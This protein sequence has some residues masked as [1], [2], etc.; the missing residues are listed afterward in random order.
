M[1]AARRSRHQ[2]SRAAAANTHGLDAKTE[3]NNHFCCPRRAECRRASARRARS[4][5]SRGKSGAV[6][7]GF[8]KSLILFNF[9]GRVYRGGGECGGAIAL[10]ALAFH[11]S[12]QSAGRARLPAH[13]HAGRQVGGRPQPGGVPSVS[14]P[15]EG[16]AP[17]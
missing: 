5:E 16:P 12:A 4:A 11:F 15:P 3:Q 14:G 7:A 9:G 8:N 2:P 17:T 6:C 13:Q 1:R 10:A